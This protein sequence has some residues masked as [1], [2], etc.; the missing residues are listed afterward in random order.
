[1][2]SYLLNKRITFEKGVSAISSVLTHNL[3]YEEYATVWANVY[4][5]SMNVQFGDDEQLLYTSEFTIRYNSKTKE[6]NN[7]FRIKYNNN[8]YKI[9]EI[10]P[11][12][13]EEIKII[14]EHYYDE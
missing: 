12:S 5:R 8:Y 11:T 4:V 13:K 1:M 6:I 3:E 14:A 2:L 9:L 7:K 10:I